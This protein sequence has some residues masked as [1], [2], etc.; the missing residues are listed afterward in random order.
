MNV[1]VAL[2]FLGCCAG[3]IA[4]DAIT[5]P[6]KIVENYRTA[7]ESQEQSFDGSSMEVEIQASLP[8]LK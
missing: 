4:E 5:L 2:V 3:L 1:R 6:D 8:K 7:T